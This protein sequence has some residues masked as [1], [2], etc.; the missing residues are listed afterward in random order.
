MDTKEQGYLTFIS[1]LEKLKAV[2]RVNKT[3]DGRAENS[4]EHSWHTAL[5]AITLSE[6]APTGVDILRVVHML[7]IHDVVEIDT[8]DTFLYDDTGR[9]AVAADEQKAAERIFSLLPPKKASEFLSLWQEFEEGKTKDASFAKA[10]DA[11]Q[12]LINHP[13]TRGEGEKIKGVTTSKVITKK[14]FI[15]E[16]SPQLWEMAEDAIERIREKGIWLDQ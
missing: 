1:E 11:L 15:K 5:M 6:Y 2:T 9:D 10:L 3:V 14:R 13:L 12:P 7:L 8:G 4:A 16:V